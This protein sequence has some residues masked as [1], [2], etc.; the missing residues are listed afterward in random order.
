[1][2]SPPK[3][4]QFYCVFLRRK[5]DVFG[6]DVAMDH[7]CGVDVV[8]HTNLVYGYTYYC[9]THHRART[10][11]SF[12]HYGRTSCGHTVYGYT[13]Y[14]SLRR[15]CSP[16]PRTAAESTAPLPR[17]KQTPCSPRVRRAHLVRVRVVGRSST[18]EA[19]LQ[20]LSH[21]PSTAHKHVHGYMPGC[22]CICTCTCTCTCTCICICICI[23][24]SPATCPWV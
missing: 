16:L 12:T 8:Y 2:G 15:E 18:P 23:C 7:I 1:M 6:L 11:C 13:Y 4:T 24:I 22:I 19:L 20:E 14:G 10:A 17:G 3:I 5:E 9:Y 21:S